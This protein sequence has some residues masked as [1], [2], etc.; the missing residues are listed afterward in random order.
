METQTAFL[1][2]QFKIHNPSKRRC[3]MLLDAMRRSHLGYDK[4]L[5]A[6]QDDVVKMVSMESK[7]EALKVL[8]KKLRKLARPLPLG[9]GPKQSI[10]FDARSQIESYLALK[11]TDPNTSYP[12]TGQLN[13]TREDVEVAYDDLANSIDLLTENEL[14]DLILKKP[15][16]PG[17]PRPLNILANRV[18]DGA[19]ILEDGKGRLFAYINLLPATARRA[20]EVNFD[21]LIDTRTGEV[22]KG[23]T[24]SGEI[25]PLECGVWH[26]EK[27]LKKGRIQSSRLIHDGKDF[28]FYASFGFEAEIIEPTNFMGVD[29]GLENLAAW[30][31]IDPDGK[32]LDQGIISGD[33]LSNVQ[34]REE[35]KQKDVQRSGRIYRSK[36]RKAI[37]EEE[38]H[39]TANA[40]FDVA[41]K[42]NALVVLED[43]NPIQMG[44]HQKRPKGSRK[45]GFRRLLSRSQYGK[46]QK[47]VDYRLQ[48]GGFAPMGR[49]KASFLEIHPAYTSRTCSRCGHEEKDN[50]KSQEEF[51]CLSCGYENNADKN[52]SEIIASKG[53]HFSQVVKGRKKGKKLKEEEKFPT[54]F[55]NRKIGGGQPSAV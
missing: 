34:R 9:A 45:G 29:R 22:M 37:A 23:K 51:L 8:T 27:F 15:P 47:Y 20:S 26:I 31:V 4:L 21:G 54:W 18:G 13:A 40:I 2:T 7:R 46:L 49:N 50:R 41:K 53:L 55:K 14:R 32:R 10:Q 16:K 36:A 6:V 24:K 17:L 28:Y 25:F 33:R 39:K 43:L 19:L 11:K 48:M 35:K 44:P 38:V 3:A 1:T 30:T 42:Y 12:T 52:A 5:R